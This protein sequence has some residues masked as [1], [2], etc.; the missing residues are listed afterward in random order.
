MK[1]RPLARGAEIRI[2]PSLKARRKGGRRP[3]T[4]TGAGLTNITTRAGEPSSSFLPDVPSFRFV[5]SRF[6]VSLHYTCRHLIPR[7]PSCSCLRLAFIH[8]SHLSMCTMTTDDTVDSVL[9]PMSHAS[10]FFY[11]LV[12]PHTKHRSAHI[13]QQSTHIYTH[14]LQVH[15]SPFHA[16]PITSGS[17]A[18]GRMM[19]SSG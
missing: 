10:A 14:Y 6:S 8:F 17:S 15:I 19:C 7:F 13:H 12:I 4:G 5:N 9:L 18:R 16:P 2:T 3:W 1:V 11:S